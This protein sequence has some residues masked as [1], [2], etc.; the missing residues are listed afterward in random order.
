[1]FEE[2]DEGARAG[3]WVPLALLSLL[4]IGVLGGLAVQK[5]FSKAEAGTSAART[6]VSN[7]AAKAPASP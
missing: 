6:A 2:I 1:M 3:I 4:L 5:H 7:T